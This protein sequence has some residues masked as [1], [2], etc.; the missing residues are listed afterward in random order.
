MTTVSTASSFNG[1]A[2]DFRLQFKRRIELFGFGLIK[3]G[4]LSLRFFDA[5]GI[6]KASVFEDQIGQ[7]SVSILARQPMFTSFNTKKQ[8]NRDSLVAHTSSAFPR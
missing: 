7:S 2:F 4:K 6:A 3:F 8:M 1:T 5:I